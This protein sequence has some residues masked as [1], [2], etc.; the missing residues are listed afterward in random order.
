MAPSRVTDVADSAASPYT[1]KTGIVASTSPSAESKNSNY[2]GNMNTSMI[3]SKFLS[4][5]EELGV[6][7]VGFSG[8]QVRQSHH[9]SAWITV[10][11]L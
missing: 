5:P 8:G 3:E 7:A 4:H 2:F 10:L 1:K 6:V 11:P 9:L